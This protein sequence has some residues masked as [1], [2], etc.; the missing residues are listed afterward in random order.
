MIRGCF[1]TLVGLV[2]IAIVVVVAGGAL[3][4]WAHSHASTIEH[5]VTTSSLQ[6]AEHESK[7]TLCTAANQAAA[8]IGR[9]ATI[10]GHRFSASDLRSLCKG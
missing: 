3:L 6:W 1:T 10:D 2:V 9:S 8:A 5:N 7:S 4:H